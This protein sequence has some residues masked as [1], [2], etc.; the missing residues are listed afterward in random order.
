MNIKYFETVNADLIRSPGWFKKLL[1]C[2]LLSF[3]PVFGQIVI[4]GYLYA[5]AREAAWGI[6]RP[7]PRRVFGNED[8][9]LYARGGRVFV[10]QFVYMLIPAA[11]MIGAYIVL[12]MMAFYLT[13]QPNELASSGGLG[14]MGVA[15]LLM[16]VAAL[17]SCVLQVFAWAGAMR[18]TVY[19]SIT[20]GLRFSEVLGMLKRDF[21][22]I[23]RIFGMNLL[24]GMIAS[25]V[26]S[27]AFQLVFCLMG[28]MV[29]VFMTTAADSVMTGE[30][31]WYRYFFVSLVV[32]VPLY[33][34][35]FM[36]A[37][38]TLSLTSRALGY[39]ARGILPDLWQAA[40]QGFKEAE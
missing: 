9:Q 12:I 29:A 27:L 17:L 33:Y 35:S 32:T 37:L 3:I 39:W 21:G 40:P 24:V 19:G 15:I 6:Q 8:G 18:A 4:N 5:W 7:L 28:A 1:V 36:A 30:A 10:V 14:I 16:I 31:A 20:A 13:A 26:V 25:T 38:Y 34:A 2:G 11:L 23:L 22:G